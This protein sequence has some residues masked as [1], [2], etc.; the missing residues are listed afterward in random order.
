MAKIGSLKEGPIDQIR[1]LAI[2]VLSEIRRG[3]MI[4][5]SELERIY[6]LSRTILPDYILETNSQGVELPERRSEE[7]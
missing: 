7:L 6:E 5:E 3:E 1:D 2:Y 4:Q